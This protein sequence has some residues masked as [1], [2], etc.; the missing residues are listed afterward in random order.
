MIP[1]DEDVTGKKNHM[2]AGR[3]KDLSIR[4]LMDIEEGNI[5]SEFKSRFK[6]E[7]VT[8]KIHVHGQQC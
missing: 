2:S 3:T 5:L 8:Q 4:S 6:M 1:Y 7:I